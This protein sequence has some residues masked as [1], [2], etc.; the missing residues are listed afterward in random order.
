VRSL[1]QYL[2]NVAIVDLLPAGFEVV[3]QSEAPAERNEE[4]APRPTAAEGEE[5]QGE[6]E[7]EAEVP[8]SDEHE[9]VGAGGPGLLSIALPGST[10]ALDYLDVR[11]DRVVLYGSV[12]KEMSSF[13][14]RIKATNSGKVVVPAIHAESMYDRGVRAR[15]EP[16]GL[17]VTRP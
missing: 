7:G 14:Y 11:E 12:G 3:M 15:G 9:P 13:L 1:E 10:F 5:G 4:A 17:N 2:D 8:E 16:G 6:G